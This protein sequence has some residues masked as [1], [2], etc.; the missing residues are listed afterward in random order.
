[1]AFLWLSYIRCT[2]RGAVSAWAAVQID[3][4]E[5]MLPVYFYQ[6][7]NTLKRFQIPRNVRSCLNIRSPSLSLYAA[8]SHKK[9][10][11]QSSKLYIEVAMWCGVIDR[12]T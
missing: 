10:M 4:E 5:I 11:L 2:E 3:N 6:A 8:V 9:A 7:Q 1:M 12:A